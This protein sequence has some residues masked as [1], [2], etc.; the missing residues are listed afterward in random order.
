MKFLL[1]ILVLCIVWVFWDGAR[2]SKK[3]A[4]IDISPDDGSD[5]NTYSDAALDSTT[6]TTSDEEKSA[7]ETI[8]E[9]ISCPLRSQL[10][11]IGW[12]IESVEGTEVLV[13]Y[14][15][16]DPLVL[17]MFD[18]LIITKKESDSIELSLLSKKY[19][20]NAHLISFINK[21]ASKYGK[22]EFGMGTCDSSD[23]E[24]L[25]RGYFKRIWNGVCI[26][27]AGRAGM[28]TLCIKM[29]ITYIA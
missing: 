27:Q 19:A 15:Q 25:K 1:I 26:Y 12:K 8:E 6:P 22:D 7:I 18:T 10:N 21:Y 3:R 29:I 20:P 11:E 9:Y 14:V 2:K 5:P 4:N 17:D 16:L 28:P 13:K 24:K 23:I